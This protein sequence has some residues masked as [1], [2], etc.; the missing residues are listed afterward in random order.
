V[1]SIIFSTA[2]CVIAC[3]G[4]TAS[5]PSSSTSTASTKTEAWVVMERYSCLGSCPAY[6]LTIHADGR[7]EFVGKNQW[8]D[9]RH[10]KTLD[11]D[12]M[13]QLRDAFV[14]AKFLQMER[15]YDQITKTDL[16]GA[17]VA[18]RTP[19]GWKEVEFH[20][21]DPTTPRALVALAEQLDA[22]V[23]TEV[24]VDAD[25]GLRIEERVLF[26]D[27]DAKVRVESGVVLDAVAATLKAH[28]K[29]RIELVGHVDLD[30][31]AW[32]GRV[33]AISVRAALVG[34]GVD[35]ARLSIAGAP[36]AIVAP[37]ADAETHARQR[38]V[39]FRR[40]DAT[41]KK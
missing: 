37:D 39:E 2:A 38:Y 21:G 34:R 10:T 36:P 3:G 23:G 29:L 12:A 14:A 11:A 17:D 24:W 8:A 26:A 33:R 18:L 25:R 41:P 27:H 4:S 9:G 28:G 13:A 20:F 40:V 7:V 32:L 16:S 31:P 19:K 1:T 22:V 35:V 15:R 6:V 30:E 5:T